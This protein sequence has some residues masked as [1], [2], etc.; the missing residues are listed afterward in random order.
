VV[1][2]VI[3]SFSDDAQRLASPAAAPPSPG[4]AVVPLLV[5]VPLGPVDVLPAFPPVATLEL[6]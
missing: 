2:V 5:A 1:Q 3:L 4:G 6:F